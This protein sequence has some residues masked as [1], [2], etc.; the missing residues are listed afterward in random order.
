MHKLEFFYSKILVKIKY[1]K[2]DILI[3]LVA[4]IFNLTFLHIFN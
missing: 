3:Y 2:I 4:Y 1:N